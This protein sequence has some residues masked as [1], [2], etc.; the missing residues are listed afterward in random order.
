VADFSR[1][2]LLTYSS[3][4]AFQVLYAVVPLALVTVA[5]LSLF[6]ER[7]LYADH[8]APV[9]RRHLS[10]NAYGIANRTATKAMAAHVLFWATIG[11]GITLWGVGAALR[12]MMTPLNAIY[13]ARESRSW[14][15][16]LLVSLAGGLLVIACL[17]AAAVVVLGGRLVHPH[18]VAAPIFFAGRW[19]VALALLLVTI[20]VILRVVPAKNRPARWISIGSFLSA[21][22]STR[23]CAGTSDAGARQVE[24]VDR[25]VGNAPDAGRHEDPRVQ[26]RVGRERRGGA[27]DLDPEPPV[28]TVAREA[29]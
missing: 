15:H 22:A 9:L 12:S 23:T 29:A 13:R 10:P 27:G 1:H 3:A 19:L 5:G 25:L 21:S 16:R 26:H 17:F 8:I 28:G 7:S 24:A 2:D 20:A 11:L 4:I 18:G 6:G 14:S